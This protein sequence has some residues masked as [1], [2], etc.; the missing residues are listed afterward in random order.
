MSEAPSGSGK[1][2]VSSSNLANV[3]THTVYFTNVITIASNG[4][5]GSSTFSLNTASD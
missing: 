4:P 1:I 5:A 2:I 3:N